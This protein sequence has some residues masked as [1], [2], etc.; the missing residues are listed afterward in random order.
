ME[1]KQRADVIRFSWGS[2]PIDALNRQTMKELQLIARRE[3]TTIEQVMS[4]ALDWC[5]ATHEP[6]SRQ[7]QKN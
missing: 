6:T 3:G 1:E 5:L 4:R 7:A 2:L